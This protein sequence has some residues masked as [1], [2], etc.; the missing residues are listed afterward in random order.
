MH[1]QENTHIKTHRKEN[2]TDSVQSYRKRKFL[3]VV[4]SESLM[5]KP[6]HLR[7]LSELARPGLDLTN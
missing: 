6:A 2:S 4:S 1:K 5:L 3:S 7:K